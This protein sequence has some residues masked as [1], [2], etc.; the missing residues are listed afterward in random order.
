VMVAYTIAN[1]LLGRIAS[2]RGLAHSPP[3]WW[4]VWA[5]CAP[6]LLI[7]IAL[8]TMTANRPTLPLANATACV[9]ATLVGLALALMPGSLAAQRPRDLGWLALDGAGLMPALLLLRAI[10]LPGRGL[11]STP[12]AFLAAVGG[13]LA[14]A[15]WLGAVTGLRVL[16]HRSPPGAGAL[17]VSG[18]CLSYLLMPLA[19]HLLATPRGYRYISTASN[20][21]AF[22]ASIQLMAFAVAAALALGITRLRQGLR[23]LGPRS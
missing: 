3:V 16:R 6:A 17:F 15:I 7:G 20:F 8:I 18:L 5:L 9:V 23:G 1:W 19:H 21:F 14:G 10:E 2:R 22:D 4:R 13:T 12:V 11:V